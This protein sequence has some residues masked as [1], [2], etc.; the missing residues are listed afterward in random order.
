MKIGLFLALYLD[1]SLKEAL[2]AAVAAGCETVE[3]MSGSWSPHCHP[4]DLLADP[5]RAR[6]H[7]GARQRPWS[8]DLGALVPANPLHPNRGNT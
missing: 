2:D 7:R 6:A 5:G 4:G 1:R 8:D 3:I